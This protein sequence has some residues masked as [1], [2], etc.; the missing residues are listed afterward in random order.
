DW[1]PQTD[2]LRCSD[3]FHD[4]P[5][6]DCVLYNAEADP[7]S[8]ARLIALL[9]CQVSNDRFFDLAFVDRFKNS[10]WRPK[11]NWN[12]CRVVEAYGKPAFL[13]LEYIARGAFLTPAYG[14]EQDLYF[15]LDTVDEDMFLRLNY[16][17]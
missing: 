9:R 12:G 17:D 1:S 14:T 6:H 5:R 13:P 11:T 10:H 2:I 16:I 15:P 4:R 3:S 8:L 7:L